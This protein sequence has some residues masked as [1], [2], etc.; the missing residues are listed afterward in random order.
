MSRSNFFDWRRFMLLMR[1]DLKVNAQQYLLSAG[2][3]A[4]GLYLFF[5]W[6]M[7]NSPA[8]FAHIRGDYMYS[9]SGYNSAFVF[10]LLFL[11][12][13]VGVTFVGI[14]GK[15]RRTHFLMLPASSFEKFLQPLLLRFVGG[16]LTWCVLFWLTANLAQSTVLHFPSVHQTFIDG[17]LI[18]PSAFKYSYIFNS[19]DPVSVIVFFILSLGAFLFSAPLFFRKLALLKGIASFFACL[20]CVFILFVFCS[21]IFFPGNYFMDIRLDNAYYK[22]GLS[23]SQLYMTGIS[24]VSWAFFLIIGYFRLKETRI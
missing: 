3:F 13:F 14:G 8:E 1:Y 20:F 23:Y 18:V 10:M 5:I 19:T 4:A 12:A 7:Y 24:W 17:K 15:I 6:R 16:I 9:V 11:G 21:H 2:G 22:P